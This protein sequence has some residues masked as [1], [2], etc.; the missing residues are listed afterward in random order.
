MD[1][2]NVEGALADYN[3]AIRLDPKSHIYFDNRA[4]A[5]ESKGEL[6]R[7][8]ADHDEAI[9]LAP[10]E[11]Y[12]YYSRG[13]TRQRMGDFDG[14]LADF[15]EAIRLGP[16]QSLGYT[17]RAFLLIP[18]SSLTLGDAQARLKLYQDMKPYHQPD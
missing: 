1:V 2:G 7:A 4:H 5:L 6:D 3:E 18:Q 12:L 9:R 15:N 8:L 13:G 14:A 10:R 11:P 16:T 17:G